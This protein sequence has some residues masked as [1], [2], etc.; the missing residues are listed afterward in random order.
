MNGGAGLPPGS[1]G[2]GAGALMRAG[3]CLVQLRRFHRQNNA[4]STEINA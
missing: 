3:V 2:Y 4:C 1:T